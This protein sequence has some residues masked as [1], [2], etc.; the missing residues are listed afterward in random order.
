MRKIYIA[1]EVA[2]N[3]AECPHRANDECKLFGEILFNRTV[4]HPTAGKKAVIEFARAK[5]CETA[6]TTL[7]SNPRGPIA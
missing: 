6:P 4:P 1:H 3:C 2:D 5:R 7:G